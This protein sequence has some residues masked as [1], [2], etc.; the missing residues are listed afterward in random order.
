MSENRSDLAIKIINLVDLSPDRLPVASINRAVQEELT[1]P[2]NGEHINIEALFSEENKEKLEESG[3]EIQ[4]GSRAVLPPG[5][6]RDWQ[7]LISVD[8]FEIRKEAKIKQDRNNQK[9]T[10]VSE[11]FFINRHMKLQKDHYDGA[12]SMKI[13][14]PQGNPYDQFTHYLENRGGETVAYYD[15][16][17]TT[18]IQ[19]G[20]DLRLTIVH[21]YLAG[22]WMLEKEVGSGIDIVVTP[23]SFTR[24]QVDLE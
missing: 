11:Q 5:T 4:F 23:A 18:D 17:L 7:K 10:L 15:E 19:T 9:E 6:K 2:V 1:V 21:P 13:V 22:D 16:L 14:L 8:G 3:F 24:D 12:M 20:L